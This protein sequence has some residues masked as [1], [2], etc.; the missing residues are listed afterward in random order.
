MLRVIFSNY[1]HVQY[2]Y[3]FKSPI[4]FFFFLKENIA[5]KFTMKNSGLNNSIF[6]ADSL[7][8]IYFILIQ[9]M[10]NS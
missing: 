10:C 4:Q 2:F 3:E 1:I 9:I 8:S 6:R 5:V 7:L